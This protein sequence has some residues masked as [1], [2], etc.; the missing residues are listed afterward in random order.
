MNANDFKTY[1]SSDGIETDELAE[2]IENGKLDLALSE[3]DCHWQEVMRHAE[4]YGFISYA[5]GGVATL[6]SNA[7]YCKANVQKELA[8]RLRMNNVEL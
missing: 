7:A 5:Y 2:Q 1:V 3:L 4:K 8:K 6:T